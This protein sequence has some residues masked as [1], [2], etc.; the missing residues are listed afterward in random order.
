MAVV[1]LKAVHSD[2]LTM[3]FPGIFL[4]IFL[5]TLVA[6][7]QINPPNG[8]QLNFNQIMLEHPAEKAVSAY[9]IQ[10]SKTQDFSTAV[11]EVQDSFS[12]TVVSNLAFRQDYFWRYCSIVNGRRT[13]W[14]KT[15]SFSILP[16]PYGVNSKIRMRVLQDNLPAGAGGLVAVDEFRCIFNRKGELV[17]FMPIVD[18]GFRKGAGTYDLNVTRAGTLTLLSA[19]N[20]LELD[21][22]SRVLWMTPFKARDTLF[23]QFGT[24]YNHDL[25]RLANNNYMVI[26]RHFFW[27]KIPEDY[28]I[29]KIPYYLDTATWHPVKMDDGKQALAMAAG[30]FLRK[31]E[32]GIYLLVNMADITEFDRKDSIVWHWESNNYI[33]DEDFLPKGANLRSGIRD[34]EPRL[35]GLSVDAGNKFVYASFRNLNRIVKIEKSTGKV[36]N[37]WGA[38]LPSGQALNGDGFFHQQHA[39]LIMDDGNM[40]VFNNADMDSVN[41]P[42][43]VEIFSQGSEKEPARV[44]WKFDCRFVPQVIRNKSNRAGNVDVLP[45]GDFLVCMGGINRVFEVNRDKEVKWNALL[46]QRF[47]N[48]STWKPRPVYRTHYA[49]SL[50]P[51]YF[52]VET[53]R[54]TVSSARTGFKLTIS[55]AGSEADSYSISVSSSA[56]HYRLKKD[57]V[58]IAGRKKAQFNIQASGKPVKGERIEIAVTSDNNPDLERTLVVRCE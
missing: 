24:F 22:Y 12:A 14:S 32:D 47:A 9:I 20:G 28:D 44:L 16:E 37:S 27:K 54:D 45:N 40:L 17:W 1:K 21:L 31:K 48:D 39:P 25:K 19:E 30:F 8:A 43:S 55:N 3:R 2:F 50:Y 11:L 7:A 10:V 52:T 13:A 58:K 34:Q 35:N 36:V 26:G 53:D 51:C 42:S 5:P 38:K 57:S 49:S 29:Y 23:D 15:Y 56:K 18:T 41:E 33:K 6:H 46:E 4:F